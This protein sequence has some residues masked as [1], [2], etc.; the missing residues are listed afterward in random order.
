MIARHIAAVFGEQVLGIALLCPVDVAQHGSRILPFQTVL[1]KDPDLLESLDPDARADYEAMAVVQSREN[2]AL[3]RDSVLPGLRIFDQDAIDRIS[4]SYALSVEP[5]AG[6][7]TFQGP[8]VFIMGRQ[9]HVV[10]FQDQTVLS[11]HYLQSTIAILDR[12]GHNAH[13]D[14]AEITGALL[15]EWLVRLQ[16]WKQSGLSR[17]DLDL[18]VA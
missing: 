9:D 15:E 18:P 13:L 7:P 4:E 8:A 3:F 2:W 17:V 1:R 12:A 6:S 11:G 10:G 5:E 16:D 14:Q